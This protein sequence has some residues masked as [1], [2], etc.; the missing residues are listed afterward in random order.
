MD[1]S[2]LDIDKKQIPPIQKKRILAFVNHFLIQTTTFLNKF[3]N[4]CEAKFLEVERKIQTVEAALVIVEAKLNSIPGIVC[5]PKA[6]VTPTTTTTA[7][8]NSPDKNKDTI[9]NNEKKIET[10]VQ[11]EEV[12]T[13]KVEEEV[14]GVKA[15]EDFRYKKYFKMVQ[16]GVP[17]SGVKQKMSAEG[18]DPEIL[19][20]PNQILEDGS[21]EPPERDTE[22]DS[23]D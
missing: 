15:C 5:T 4:E 16:F 10:E 23:S 18:F 22:T 14:K 19:D 20:K 9:D 12:V 3:S 7:V 1:T 8:E 2:I 11:K 21:T 17:P 13:E 6:T